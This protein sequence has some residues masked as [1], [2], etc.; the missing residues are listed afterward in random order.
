[1]AGDEFFDDPREQSL[2]KSEIVRKYFWA[3]AKVI[4]PRAKQMGKK[5]AYCDL[6]CGPG[7]FEDGTES[8]P[9][10]I[11]KTALRDDEMRQ[12]LVTW[13]ND[14]NPD[15]VRSL[16]AAIKAAPGIEGLSRKPVVTCQEVGEDI[17]ATLKRSKMP[18][19][20]FVDP[21][22]YKGLSLNLINTALEGWGCDCIFFFNYNRIN[23]ALTNPVLSDNM[24]SIFGPKTAQELSQ[25]LAGLSPKARELAVV[26]AVG[27]ALQ[28]SGN[29]YVLP[30]R[31]KT[32]GKT[33]HHLVFVSKNVLGYTIMKEIM[34]KESSSS[35][36]GYASFEYN[37]ATKDQPILYGLSVK[38]DELGS[39][40]LTE[41]AGRTL[42]MR[43]IFEAHHIGH[44]FVESNYKHVLTALEAEGSITADP[45]AVPAPGQRARRKNT[46]GPDVRVSFPS[47][48]VR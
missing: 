44:P 26:E 9:L 47:R 5:V 6:F 12:S 11:L 20:V 34:W 4:I 3:W 2:V 25:R 8:T 42:T 23:A 24:S 21:W 16:K 1:M 18:T 36:E 40:L 39:M 29:R 33:S 48:P 45:P 22:G 27:Q 7:I 41:F 30:F 10:V 37:P 15:Y 35:P 19:L 38:Q 32:T 17:V 13:F 43:E 31:F 28:E 14:R 46:F